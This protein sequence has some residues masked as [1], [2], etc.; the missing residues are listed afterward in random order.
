M[1]MPE[2]RPRFA[3]ED[4][5]RII[6]AHAEGRGCQECRPGWCPTQEWALWVVVTA[7][8]QLPAQLRPMVTVVARLVMTAHW[9]RGI[10]GCRPCGQPDCGRI[11]VAGSWLETHDPGWAPPQLR[12]VLPSRVPSDEEL[13]RITGIGESGSGPG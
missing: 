5:Y 8:R 12:A 1:M 2:G 6:T 3:I 11:I 13:R 10:D 7:G 4:A 9:P